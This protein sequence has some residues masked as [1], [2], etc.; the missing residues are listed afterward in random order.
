MLLQNL[1]GRLEC[2]MGWAEAGQWGE[3]AYVQ[4]D[5]ESRSLVGQQ[6]ELGLWEGGE[7]KEHSGQMDKIGA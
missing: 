3:G 6:E 7:G 5:G 4:G 1:W 2:V